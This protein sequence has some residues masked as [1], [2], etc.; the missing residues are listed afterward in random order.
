[1]LCCG[2]ESFKD[3]IFLCAHKFCTF[4]LL[5]FNNLHVFLIKT[6]IVLHKMCSMNIL[7]QVLTREAMYRINLSLRH[8]NI[9]HYRYRKA[10]S[11]TYSGCVTVTFVIQHTKY[12]CLDYTVCGRYGSYHIFKHYLINGMIL[13]KKKRY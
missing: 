11:I 7:F 5:L 6:Q 9:N 1:M 2:V 8:I 13:K 4:E 10:T 3:Q 12:T